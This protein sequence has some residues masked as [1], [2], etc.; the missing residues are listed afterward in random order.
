MNA[1]PATL[2]HSFDGASVSGDAVAQPPCRDGAPSAFAQ[3]LRRLE[4]DM[5]RGA[6]AGRSPA[7]PDQ[8]APSRAVPM[9]VAASAADPARP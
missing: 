2:R 8:T 9:L 1:A 7:A 6:T 5:W 3:T 4:Q